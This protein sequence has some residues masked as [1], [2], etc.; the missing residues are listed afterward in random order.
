MHSEVGFHLKLFIW[1]SLKEWRLWKRLYFKHNLQAGKRRETQ[2]QKLLVTFARAGS[3]FPIQPPS[4]APVPFQGEN[5]PLV[6]LRDNILR[7][8]FPRLFIFHRQRRLFSGPLPQR[9]G[10]GCVSLNRTGR[11]P[12]P[13][14][15]FC[16][17]S[18]SREFNRGRMPWLLNGFPDSDGLEN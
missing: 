2:H 9:L 10:L 11:P 17:W 14:P 5:S 7:L 18:G 16:V 1:R 8:I 4:V 3:W 13:F 15:T 6:Y 12:A